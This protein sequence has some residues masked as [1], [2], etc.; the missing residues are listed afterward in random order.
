[1]PEKETPLALALNENLRLRLLLSA[2]PDPIPDTNWAPVYIRWWFRNRKQLRAFA[3]PV[4][5]AS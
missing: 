3:A 1:M 4:D 2:L 5:N